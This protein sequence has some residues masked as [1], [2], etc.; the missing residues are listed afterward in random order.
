MATVCLTHF[1]SVAGRQGD[2]VLPP[3]T[4]PV[5]FKPCPESAAGWHPVPVYWGTLDPDLSGA[6]LGGSTP[7]GPSH[8]LPRAEHTPGR[9]G[10]YPIA[11]QHRR[12]ESYF[13]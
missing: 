8:G 9:W 4:T 11:S 6:I 2:S 5:A 10:F 12:E 7:L 3:G 1:G 13:G